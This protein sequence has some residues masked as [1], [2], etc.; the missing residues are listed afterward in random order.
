[1]PSGGTTSANCLFPS[2]GGITLINKGEGHSFSGGASFGGV[3]GS[4]NYSTSF[5]WAELNSMDMNGD[6]YPDILTKDNIQFTSPIGGLAETRNLGFGRVSTGNSANWGLSASGTFI[7]SKTPGTN[8][9][10]NIPLLGGGILPLVIPLTS[11]QVKSSAGINSSAGGG[12][13]KEKLLWTDMNGDGLPDRIN[14]DGGI[15]VSLNLG[16]G[17]DSE[18][19]WV[20]GTDELSGTQSN[21]SGGL[22]FSFGDNAYSGGISASTS[23]AYTEK[24]IADINGDG[25]PDLLLDDGGG[26]LSYRLN[27]G[28]RFDTTTH[29]NNGYINF[30]RSTAEGLNGSFSIPIQIGIP[31]TP[32][33]L[34]IIINPSFGGEQSLNR[35]ENSIEDI[36][37]DGFADILSAGAGGNSTNDGEL[38]ARLSKIG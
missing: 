24:N 29:S 18:K 27:T 30:N 35:T 22:G 15:K 6:R 17:F 38:H 11:P 3:G 23:K 13:N 2:I 25:L 14:V 19:T 33:C 1:M 9:S 4:T 26:N 5:N 12:E 10:I 28:N 20:N 16:Y 8:L 7:T 37:G 34:Q 31:F 32:I 36:N 21:F